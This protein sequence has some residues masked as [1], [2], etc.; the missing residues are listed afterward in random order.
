[1]SPT[2]LVVQRVDPE[3]AALEG[4]LAQQ[5]KAETVSAIP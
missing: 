4:E 2:L 5:E 1:M 3:D